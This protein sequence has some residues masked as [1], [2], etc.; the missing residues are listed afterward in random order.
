[1]LIVFAETLRQGKRLLSVPSIGD[2]MSSMGFGSAAEH[3]E[4]T[5]P[6]SAFGMKRD[7]IVVSCLYLVRNHANCQC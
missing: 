3:T 5:Q 6:R 1:M 2:F 7:N 4:L